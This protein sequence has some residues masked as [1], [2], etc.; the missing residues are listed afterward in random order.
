MWRLRQEA[1][2][3]LGRGSSGLRKYSPPQ[4]PRP[5][6]WPRARSSNSDSKLP[7]QNRQGGKRASKRIKQSCQ[8]GQ[9]KTAGPTSWT[10]LSP[11]RIL[12]SPTQV[13]KP[14]QLLL[15]TR[16]PPTWAPTTTLAPAW[17]PPVPRSPAPIPYP[18]GCPRMPR[19]TP[20]PLRAPGSPRSSMA[21]REATQVR[22]MLTCQ[23]TDRYWGRSKVS[24]AG[25]SGHP[26]RGPPPPRPAPRACG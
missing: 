19:R 13:G 22:R 2:T 4:Y 25:G 16:L 6:Q 12:V 17:V 3:H 7:R 1:R 8:R 26:S 24:R 15:P 14:L 9:S 18:R 23:T 11:H 10:M 20:L 21:A 5:E